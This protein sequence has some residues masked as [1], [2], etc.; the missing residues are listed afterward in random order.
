M[1]TT[2]SHEKHRINSTWAYKI[3]GLYSLK[4]Q[5]LGAGEKRVCM[6]V[7]AHA[8][9]K[10]NLGL[11]PGTTDGL[12]PAR[13]P[14]HL[15]PKVIK[16]KKKLRNCERVRDW[17]DHKWAG[18]GSP[19]PRKSLPGRNWASSSM[20][21]VWVRTATLQLIW[22]GYTHRGH[23]RGNACSTMK[24]DL[25]FIVINGHDIYSQILCVT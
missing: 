17:D 24:E 5:D 20:L 1:K 15:K 2:H 6:V 9:H 22:L 8:L 12:T 25:N 10:V 13:S 4:C 16:A 23:R 21:C 3:T 14:E 7:K 11:V 19:I 18:A